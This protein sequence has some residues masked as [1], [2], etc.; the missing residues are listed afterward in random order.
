VV[1]LAASFLRDDAEVPTPRPLARLQDAVKRTSHQQ[2]HR[3][4]MLPLGMKRDDD[5]TEEVT[6]DEMVRICRAIG[7]TSRWRRRP[8]Q[9]VA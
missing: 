3:R 2:A 9:D 6:F 8:E 1:S 4:E 7:K 5:L